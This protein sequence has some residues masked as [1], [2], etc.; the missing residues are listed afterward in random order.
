MATMLARRFIAR[1]LP[2]A[3]RLRPFSS[4][5]PRCT[6]PHVEYPATPTKAASYAT[7]LL[8][9]PTPPTQPT[10]HGLFLLYVPSPPAHWSSHIEMDDKLVD[11]VGKAMALNGIRFVVAHDPSTGKGYHG[12]LIVPDG[13][14]ATFPEFTHDTISSAE[15][16]RLVAAVR[17]GQ[18]QTTPLGTEILVCTH[19][20]RDCRCSD[21]GGD[22]VG[23]LRHEIAR[24]GG[25]ECRVT[26]CAHVGGHK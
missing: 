9:L 6:P 19:G 23:A 25:A 4:S 22:L 14:V 26:E 2:S 11:D 12:K 8:P 24:R 10:S 21:I 5:R 13:L 16:K 18:A 3:V 7:P 15:L 17:A 20:A 1:R